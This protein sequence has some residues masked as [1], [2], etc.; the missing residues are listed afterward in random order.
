M[1]ITRQ[2]RIFLLLFL[3][4]GML[5]LVSLRILPALFTVFLSF[6]DWD[7]TQPY[8]PEFIGLQNYI[9]IWNDQPFIDSIWRSL[10]FTVVATTV[11]LFFGFVIALFVHRE[12]ILKNTLRAAI[13]TPMVITPS[14]VGV[15]WSIMFHSSVGPLNWLLG[16]VG[17]PAVGWLTT[18]NMAMLSVVITDVWHW[19]PFMFL[20]CLS[21]MQMIPDDLYESAEV[22]GASP[23]QQLFHITI[24]MVRETLIVAIILRSM[25]AF[26]LFAEPFVMTGGGPGT[27]TETV[28]LH[29]YKS[30]FL[31]F[32]MGYAGAMVVVCIFILVAAYSL[33]WRFIKFD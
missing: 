10:T 3:L 33:Y 25:D 26:E 23:A 7:L 12:L 11:E 17:L 15:I 31:F 5:Y 21:A 22:D 18:P 27:A 29:I 6:T 24:P 16:L 20:L 2:Q 28:S 9:D 30:A 19:T 1:T 4:P 13:L 14:I 8:G 32:Q